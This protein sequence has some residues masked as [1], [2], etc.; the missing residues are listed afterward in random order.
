MH[1][2]HIFVENFQGLRSASLDLATP[3]TLVAGFNGA[4]KSSLREA[5]GFALGGSGRVQHKKDYGKLVTEG[6][7]KAQ[8]IVSHDGAASSFAL[9][10]GT[11][12]RHSVPGDDYLPFVLTPGAFA[13]MDE[14]ARRA[15]LFKLTKSSAKPDVVVSMLAKRKA[16]ATK[17]EKIKP[18]LLSGF[19]AAQ[20]QA[21]TYAAESR[22]AWKAITGEQYGSEKAEGWVFEA[23]DSVS[24][25]D[26]REEV[27][28]KH[29]KAQQDIE[30]GNRFIGEQD[31]KRQAAQ[32]L[33]QRK[34][35]LQ[36][37]ADLFDRAVAKRT[38]TEQDL[39]KL[40]Q[41]LPDLQAQLKDQ[42][43]G[44][45][46][47]ECPACGVGLKIVGSKLELYQGLKQDT[48]ATS[49]L[50]LDI[51]NMQRSVEMLRRTLQN[52]MA[53]VAKAEAAREELKQLKGQQA[54]AFDQDRYDRS[55][56]SL[57]ALRKQEGEL[58]AQYNALCEA[59]DEA[60]NA[61]A[62]T[63]KAA[64]YHLDVLEWVLIEKALAPDGIPGEILAGALQPFNASLTR[65][66]KLT[67]WPVVQVSTE[68]DITAG[69]RLYQ[70]LSESEQWRCDT[71]LALAIAVHSGLKLVMLDRFDVLDLP[72]RGQL[73]GMLVSLAKA[74]EIESA[75]VL[76][77]LKAK[78]AK[79]PP[80][81][82]AVWIE[83]GVAQQDQPMQQAG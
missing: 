37:A 64:G 31:A 42:Q 56:E 38:T 3:I 79:L 30:N 4:G 55:I 72:A 82:S 57:N 5:I 29:A 65:T 20:E 10:K 52:D 17:V 40:E 27:F 71:L 12:E 26:E 9:P 74:N 77:T 50:A 35:E 47:C 21:K 32:G 59:A 2:E 49:T 34:A 76:G 23:P 78:P 13:A 22:G 63:Q 45:G 53:A 46:G 19:G 7:K 15:L 70:L 51:T 68:M 60:K 43:A 67:G 39:S 28:K 81:I 36:E 66:S 54:E 1:L 8:I 83:G 61:E 16:N 11:A 73:L 58:C 25:A 24:N 69:G 80:E 75:I 33:G 14:K 48:A 62:N 18:L 41:Q 6:E 44:S